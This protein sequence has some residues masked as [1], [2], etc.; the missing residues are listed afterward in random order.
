MDELRVTVVF[1]S[2]ENGGR[3][4]IPPRL[5]ESKK[6]WPHLLIKNGVEGEVEKEMG[7]CFSAQNRNLVPDEE[8]RASVLLMYDGVDYSSL[9]PGAEFLI[10]EGDKAVGRGCVIS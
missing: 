2:H 4:V 5:L 6:Y 7:V 8:I 3:L 10:L 1:Y 9:I